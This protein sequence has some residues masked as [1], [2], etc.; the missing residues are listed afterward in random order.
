[1]GGTVIVLHDRRGRPTEAQVRAANG[2]PVSRIVRS[3]SADGRISEERPTLENLS[4]LFLERMSPEER[5]QLSPALMQAMN[6]AMAAIS[7]GQREAGK[8]YSYDAQGRVT[9]TRETNF[10]FEKTTTI[11]YN[12][13]GDEVEIDITIA[14]NTAVPAGVSYSVDEEGN[15]TPIAVPGAAPEPPL[16]PPPEQIHYSYEYDRYGNWTQ[17]T[18][19]R[20]PGS[21]TPVGT[22]QRTLTYY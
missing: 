15:V 20:G 3:Y 17:Q 13:D 10:V 16:L 14:D 11:Q 9:Q 5:N 19:T 2:D 4:A 8:S 1:M 18:T 21:G 22:R 12:D 7:R 6:K